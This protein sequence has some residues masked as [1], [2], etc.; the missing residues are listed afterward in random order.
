MN[1]RVI[2]ATVLLALAAAALPAHH[3]VQSVFDFKK[4]L[5]I[6]A[7]VTKVEFI[8]PHSYVTVE[9]TDANGKTVNWTFETLALGTLRRRGLSRADKGGL[10]IGD[11]VTITGF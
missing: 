2:S 6:T 7:T 1:Y 5:N 11:E 3:A 8:N 10:K 9:K 4:P